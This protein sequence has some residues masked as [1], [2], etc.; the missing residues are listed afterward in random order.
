MR[1]RYRGPVKMRFDELCGPLGSQRGNEY[2]L[3]RSSAA[4]RV[5]VCRG[6]GRRLARICS[7]AQTCEFLFRFRI[8][9]RKLPVDHENRDSVLALWPA[10]REVA[11][12]AKHIAVK[13]CHPLSAA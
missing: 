4:A 3:S 5:R 8:S 6:G 13:I 12:G 10:R 7:I 2:R 11:F 9:T 1:K